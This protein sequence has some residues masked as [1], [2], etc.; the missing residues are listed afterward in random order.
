M[1]VIWIC[2]GIL[3]TAA[4]IALV[5]LSWG[6]SMLD[7]A[8]AT[9][10]MIAIVVCGLALQAAANRHSASLSILLVLAFVGF[11]GSVSLARFAARDTDDEG[12]GPDGRR[13]QQEGS[14]E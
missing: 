4:A 12:A 1:T 6:P 9:D 7:R 5:R 2:A 13:P 11:V 3:A 10:V 14:H 8:I